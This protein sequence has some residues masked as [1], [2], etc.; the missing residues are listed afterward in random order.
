V[1]RPS[2]Y[3]TY[4]GGLARDSRVGPIVLS[5]L[6]TWTFTVITPDQDRGP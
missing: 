5:Q 1:A 6:F 2:G 4:V 3:E